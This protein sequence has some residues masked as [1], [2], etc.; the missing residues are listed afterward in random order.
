MHG[1]C[2]A[3]QPKKNY[4]N[5]SKNGFITDAHRKENRENK[6]HRNIDDRER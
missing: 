3:A 6:V 4:E 5:N 1:Q 2:G